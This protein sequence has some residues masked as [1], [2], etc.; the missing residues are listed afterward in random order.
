MEALQN[1]G[2]G[3]SRS[4]G[5]TSRRLQAGPSGEE[6]RRLEKRLVINTI[7]GGPHSVDK[8]LNEMDKY[9]DALKHTRYENCLVIEDGTLPKQCRMMIDDVIFRNRDGVED[10]TIDPLVITTTIGSTIVRKVLVDCESSVNILFK[11]TYDQMLLEGKDL[12][13]CKFWIQGFKGIAT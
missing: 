11:T 8:S 13:P 9:A 1:D 3:N 12:R 10:P 2:Q 4:F 5:S 6:L 7:I